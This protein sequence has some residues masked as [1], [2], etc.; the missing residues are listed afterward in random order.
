ME[1]VAAV[2]LSE[3]PSSR[4]AVFG[5]SSLPKLMNLST[6]AFDEFLEG[7]CERGAEKLDS[8]SVNDDVEK[9]LEAFKKRKL[10]FSLVNGEVRGEPRTILI[11]LIDLL[12]LYGTKQIATDM[13]VGE[14]ASPIFSMSGKTS[15][16]DAL[17][18]MFR[19]THRT[20]FI[21][22]QRK[23][24]SDR[25]IIDRVLGP[26]ALETIRDGTETDTLD[27]Q[28]GALEKLT[29]IEVGARTSMQTAALRLRDWGPCLAIRGEDSVVTAWDVVM[30]PW[31][32]GRLTVNGRS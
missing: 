25:S 10:G 32:A 5:F 9:L 4:R 23:Y 27:V 19:L 6:R 29:P 3:G 22:G 11:S 8:L 21:S 24:I 17:L 13:V 31:E 20:V 7:P 26:T 12:G 1:D 18:A 30:K 15:I 14:V 16:R 28:I 2:P